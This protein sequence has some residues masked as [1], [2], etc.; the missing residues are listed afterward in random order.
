MKK[1]V[2]KEREKCDATV[3]FILPT[4][5]FGEDPEVRIV[6]IHTRIIKEPLILYMTSWRIRKMEEQGKKQGWNV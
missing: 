2:K 5:I 1:E 4:I 3:M 6:R